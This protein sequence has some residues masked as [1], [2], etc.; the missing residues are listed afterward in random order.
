MSKK[1][2]L[3]VPLAK[4]SGRSTA[5]AGFAEPTPPPSRESVRPT[6]SQRHE[7]YKLALEAFDRGN[8]ALCHIIGDVAKE[9]GLKRPFIWMEY[10]P[11]FLAQKPK[12]ADAHGYWWK[13]YAVRR[14]AL[15]KMIKASAPTPQPLP[16]RDSDRSG[17]PA[18]KRGLGTKSAGRKASPK[19]TKKKLIP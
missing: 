7:A 15:V 9:M 3:G 6:K 19:P 2:N 8:G 5:A 10:W 14:R 1:K 18:A 11:E 12:R 13:G 4:A 16:T 17:K